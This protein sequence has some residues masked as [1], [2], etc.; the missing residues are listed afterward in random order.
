MKK[1]IA[2][3]AC[4]LLFACTSPIYAATDYGINIDNKYVAG[5]ATQLDDVL[6]EALND[7]GV[8][9]VSSYDLEKKE[10]SQTVVQIILSADGV[11]MEAVC[12]YLKE[13]VWKCSSITNIHSSADDMVNY[14]VNPDE[15]SSYAFETKDYKTGEYN[16]TGAA[17]AVIEQYKTQENWFSKDDFSLCD[18]N[19]TII[20]QSGSDDYITASDY[21][22][23]QTYR[24]IEIG[25]TVSD[26]FSVYDPKHFSIQLGYKDGIGTDKEE[27]II[28]MYN[29]QIENANPKEIE[30]TISSID[31]NI[32]N[33]AIMFEGAEFCGEIIPMPSIDDK[34]SYKTTVAIGFLIENNQVSDIVVQQKERF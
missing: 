31:S 1:R 6:S 10:D 34:I 9:E 8:K 7:M 22:D 24:G 18:S 17:K 20:N 5:N 29:S 21:P 13:G 32:V 2:G 12:Y 16:P 26:I 25:N 14:W 15:A 30:S 23:S 11:A 4:L 27:K 19:G 28:D 3:L 33:I